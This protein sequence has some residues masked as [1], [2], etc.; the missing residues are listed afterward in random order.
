M[1]ITTVYIE[2]K[3]KGRAPRHQKGGLNVSK[4]EIVSSYAVCNQNHGTEVI[5]AKQNLDQDPTIKIRLRAHVRQKS[6]ETMA[7][8][9]GY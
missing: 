6:R 9:L 4:G 8:R 5:Q 7:F 3:K 2:G 1:P